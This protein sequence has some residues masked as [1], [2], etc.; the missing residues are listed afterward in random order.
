M[1][2]EIDW[3]PLSG[4]NANRAHGGRIIK[5]PLAR[6]YERAVGVRL[7]MLGLAEAKMAGPLELGLVLAP[8]DAKARDIDNLCKPL[9]DALVRGGLLADDSNRVI[10]RL[11]VE[12]TDPLPDGK[13]LV[14]VRNL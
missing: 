6:A 13:V 7:R 4:N 10:R 5:L 8:P 3:P 2:I 14:T 9:V 11:V 1:L 12:W